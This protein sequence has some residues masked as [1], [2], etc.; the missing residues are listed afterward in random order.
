MP[1]RDPS[2][3]DLSAAMAR[4]A[5][6]L[7]RPQ[8]ARLRQYCE[9]LWQWNTKINLTCHTDFEK[10]VARDLVD[11]LAIDEFL[12][13]GERILDVGTGGGVPGVVLAILFLGERLQPFHI[14]G[15]A[16][17]LPGVVLA[18]LPANALRRLRAP[19]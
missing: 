17:I 3:D 8:V 5:I 13:P 9:L 16:L 18:T 2:T 19:G 14:V 10:F 12:Q 7:P 15:F 6:E 4:H 1:P 11:S